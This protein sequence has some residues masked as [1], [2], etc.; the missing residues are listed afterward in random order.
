MGADLV[1]VAQPIIQI[2]LQLGQA[3]VKLFAECHPIELVEHRLMEALADS[4]RL[5]AL[6]LRPGMI[7]VFDRQI[8]LVFMPLR[9]AAVFAATVGSS[10]KSGMPCSS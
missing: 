2:G 3:V 4:V 9:I 10:R 1:V 5:W 6:G 7:D 8:E